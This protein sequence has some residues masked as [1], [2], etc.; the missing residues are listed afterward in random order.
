WTPSERC[1]TSLSLFQ[2]HLRHSIANVSSPADVNDAQRINLD[3]ARAQGLE[4]DLDY[5]LIDNLHLALSGLLLSTEVRSCPENPGIEGNR[6]A[7][8]PEHRAI[9][10]LLWSPPSWAIRLDLRHESERHD[11]ARNSRPLDDS[12]S[13]DLALT[14]NLSENA[15][16]RLA[17]H[18]LTDEEIQTGLSSGGII[19][20]GAPRNFLLGLEWGF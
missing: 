8:A 17:I 16:L 14:R 13:I 12:F 2:D 11:D 7:Q 5:Q 19:S 15:R 20:T 18:N 6:F 10:S 1:S 3:R 9:A 4:I